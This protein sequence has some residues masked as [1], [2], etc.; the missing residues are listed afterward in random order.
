[1]YKMSRIASVRK[2]EIAPDNQTSGNATWSYRDGNPL[3]TFSIA[4]QVLVLPLCFR[5]WKSIIQ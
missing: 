1:M 5:K 2:F 3:I 4:P